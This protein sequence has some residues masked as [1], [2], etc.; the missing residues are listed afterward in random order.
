MAVP[1]ASYPMGRD[2]G[3]VTAARG[4][5]FEG[6]GAFLHPFLAGIREGSSGT[7]GSMN[8]AAT[9]CA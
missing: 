4:P 1:A 2:P 6:R 7:N 3:S 8:W 5:R 9:A